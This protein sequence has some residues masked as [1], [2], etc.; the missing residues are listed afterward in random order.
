MLPLVS[1][2]SVIST[3]QLALELAGQQLAAHGV[4]HVVGQE[5]Q[6][7]HA[8]RPIEEGHG[9]VGLEREGVGPVGLLRQ[10]VAEHVEEQDPAV[11]GQPVDH[12]VEVE[13]RGGEAVEDEQRRLQLGAGWRDV[14]G[15]D[16]DGRTG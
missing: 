8:R 12:A 14:D 16:A 3:S 7:V 10:P 5:P 1:A 2:R 6:A 4:P 13:R 15:E 9:H 11:G